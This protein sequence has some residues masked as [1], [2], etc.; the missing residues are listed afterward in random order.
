M[1]PA[2]IELKRQRQISGLEARAR[3]P[4]TRSCRCART[5]ATSPATPTRTGRSAR[6]RASRRWRPMRCAAHLAKLRETQR[7]VLVAVG[8]LDPARVFEQAKAAFGPAAARG[9]PLGAA[10]ARDRVERQA[11]VAPEGAPHQLHQRHVPGARLE[12][13]RFPAPAMVA[14]NV[15][16]HRF[17]EEVRTK[18]NL[19]YAASAGLLLAH[20]VPYGADLHDRGRPEHDHE[21]DARRGEP[22]PDELS[23]RRTSRARNRC[24]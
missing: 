11:R 10:A 9:V 6:S 8:N 16:G 23:R 4:R 20:G 18:R 14:M 2:E 1:P 24:S 5:W 3:E 19:S 22:P 17:F 15:L 12:R 21:G 13:R 7:I